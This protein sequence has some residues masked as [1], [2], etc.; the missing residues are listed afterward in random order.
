MQAFL[1]DN[2]FQARGGV[3]EE[4]VSAAGFEYVTAYRFEETGP[5]LFGALYAINYGSEGTETSFGGRVGAARY[6]SVHSF[7]GYVD[8]MQN[9]YAFDI[10]ETT[11]NAN[12]TALYAFYSYRFAPEWQAGVSTYNELTSFD[13]ETGFEGTYNQLEGELRYRGFG[14]I[15][16]PRIGLAI[17]EREVDNEIDSYDHRHWF[18]QASTRP[19]ERLELSLRYR[20]RTRSYQNVDR[21]EDRG[22]VQFRAI[23]RH[24]PR[25]ATTATFTHENVNSSIPGRDFETSR[26][27][28]GFT[29]GF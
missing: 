24:T 6:G 27:F 5:D 19:V 2:F 25:L 14:R 8:R 10:E 9:G 20:D 7:Y 26:F 13:V 12:I 22:Q 1:F 21:E 15:F 17:A 28:A 18:V 11:A 4:D 23:F 29:I 16:E 3:P